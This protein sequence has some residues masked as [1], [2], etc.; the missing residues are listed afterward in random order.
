MFAFCCRCQGSGCEVVATPSKF[1]THIVGRVHNAKN[2]ERRVW[3]YDYNIGLKV[4]SAQL[5]SCLAPAL[6]AVT[7]R[8]VTVCI[9]KSVLGLC[10]M[11]GFVRH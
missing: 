7:V 3:R 9:S 4:G 6:A 10:S 2:G 11:R 5:L 8:A 1:A